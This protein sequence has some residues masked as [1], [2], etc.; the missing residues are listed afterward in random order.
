MINL[1]TKIIMLLEEG[2]TKMSGRGKE[3]GLGRGSGS[4]PRQCAR[5]V[6]LSAIGCA[7]EVMKGRSTATARP[8][9]SPHLLVASPGYTRGEI[10]AWK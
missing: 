4:L 7:K 3:G 1:R 10:V 8:P 6:E 9:T 5:A 2:R